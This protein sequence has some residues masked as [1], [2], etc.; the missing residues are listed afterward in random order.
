VPKTEE[1]VAALDGERAE[2]DRLNKQ[3]GSRPRFVV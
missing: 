1:L 2:N 3:V